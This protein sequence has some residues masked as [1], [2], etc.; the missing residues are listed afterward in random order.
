MTLA[1]NI[2]E[3]QHHVPRELPLDRDVILLRILASQSIR[4]VSK[5]ENRAEEGEI[6]RRPAGWVRITI[7]RIWD[8]RPILSEKRRVEEDIT[9]NGAAAKWRL[10]SKRCQ[11]RKSTRLN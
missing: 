2:A 3:L 6:H 5:Q 8:Y 4:E 10:S 9:N 11:D 7:K 1:A